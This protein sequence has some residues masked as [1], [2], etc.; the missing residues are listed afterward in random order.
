MGTDV[1]DMKRKYRTAVEGEF[2]K[3]LEEKF[4]LDSTLRYGE[5]PN[6][7]AAIYKNSILGSVNLE[8]VKEGKGGLSATNYMD[9]TRALNILKYFKEPSV[10]VMKHAIPSGFATQ[11]GKGRSLGLIYTL[12]RDADARSAFGSVVGTN[13]PIDKTTAEAIMSTYVEAVVAPGFDDGVMELFGQ[14]KNLRVVRFSNLDKIPKF[15]GDSTCGLNDIKALPGGRVLVQKPYLSSIKGGEDLV[16]D[17]LVTKEGKE[18]VVEREPNSQELKDMLTA[19]YVNLG[20]RSNGIV[21]VKDGVTLAVGSGQQERVG[22]VE[23]AIVKAYQK[24]ADRA[25]LEYDPLGGIRDLHISPLRN[26]VVSSDAFFPFRDSIDLLS[27]VGVSGVIQPG[28]SMRDHEVIDAVN[29]HEMSMAF[30][31]ER[32][33]EHF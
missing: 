31:L 1:T 23:Q 2:S 10:A 5:N 17:S 11:D 7:P 33:F 19:W 6:Q 3:I 20:V 27:K 24:A 15:V 9:V 12:A 22:A 32:C 30:T 25:G 21:F 29:E 18:Y 26:S 28:G 8:L 14:K 4:S 13:V 16:L